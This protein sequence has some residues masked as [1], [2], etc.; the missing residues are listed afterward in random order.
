MS[1]ADTKVI[2]KVAY[3]VDRKRE[4]PMNSGKDNTAKADDVAQTQISAQPGRP[5][6]VEKEGAIQAHEIG[7]AAWA[8]FCDWFTERFKDVET[9]IERIEERDGQRRI[10]ECLDRPLER[11]A[12]EVLA[13]G[14]IGIHVAVRYNGRRRVMEVA[15]PRWLRLH[16][17]AAGWPKVLEI[18]YNEG[19]LALRFTG[20]IP[21]G[22]IFTANSWGE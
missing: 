2:P 1:G 11:V 12:A 8:P 21:R 20:N 10:T 9:T 18:G 22:P 19:R 4:E 16:W 17:N 14:I 6:L 5:Q 13:D 7:M 15:G 3:T